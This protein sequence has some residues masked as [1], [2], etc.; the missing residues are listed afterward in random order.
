MKKILLWMKRCPLIFMIIISVAG[1][2]IYALSGMLLGKYE[3]KISL[4]HPLL[5]AVLLREYK[6][7]DRMN[8]NPVLVDNDDVEETQENKNKT[9]KV[10]VEKTE[11]NSKED[12]KKEAEGYETAFLT[13]EM[14][15]AKSAYYSDNDK[16]ALSTDCPYETVDDSYFEDSVFIGDSRIAGFS[17]YAG[18]G[19]ECLYKEGLTV[20]GMFEEKV[21]SKKG[22]STTLK[23]AL[24]KKQY[25]NIYIMIGINE[26]GYKTTEK[27][28]EKYQEN[29]EK[30]KKIQPESR[31]II[32]GIMKVT[33]EYS[34]RS[35]VF[36]N[37][38]I[39][40]K[41]RAIAE[42]A[43]GKD[44][45]YL[46]M[47]PSVTDEAGNIVEDYTWDGVHLKAEYYEL[48]ADFMREH[49]YPEEIEDADR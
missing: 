46:D 4:D 23:K 48:W 19:A 17:D 9:D 47:N 5:N 43:N 29:I 16:I 34:D 3:M 37:D 33:K 27:F 41:N 32:L 26:L 24:Q 12:D 38:N 10:D 49:G 20:Y 11:E 39:D 44:I 28:K 8:E 36:N 21:N 25:K 35:K 13:V 42:L 22:K 30:I 6:L 40:D 2:S 1:V 31:V 15:K 45:F 14:R 7:D 18:V